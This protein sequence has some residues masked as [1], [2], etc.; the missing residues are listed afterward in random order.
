MINIK[1]LTF[2]TIVFL[3]L[4]SNIYANDT[5]SNIEIKNKKLVTDLLSSILKSDLEGVKTSIKLGADV[6]IYLDNNN[7]FLIIEAVKI[8]NIDIIKELVE[9]GADVDREDT[10]RISTLM[11]AS[12]NGHLEVVKYLVAN[13]SPMYDISN[14][15]TAFSLAIENGHDDIAKYIK[16]IS[17][18]IDSANTGDFDQVKKY[19]EKG[20]PV[21]SLVDFD[22]ALTVASE[23]GHLEIVQYL[24]DNGAKVNGTRPYRG[25]GDTALSIA[26][27]NGHFEIVK[28]LIKAGAK[29]NLDDRLGGTALMGASENGHVKIVKLLIDNGADINAKTYKYSTALIMS[30]NY[31]VSKLLLDNGADVKVYNNLGYTALYGVTDIKLAKLLIDKGADLNATLVNDGSTPLIEAVRNNNFKIVKLLVESGADMSIKD[32]EEMTALQIAC[33]LEHKEICNYLKKPI[34]EILNK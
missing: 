26:S 9:S 2:L 27:Q 34:K 33:N 7:S 29:V 18:F 3:F 17:I 25:I 24:I 11:Y 12:K 8:G 5:V 32:Y 31:K 1:N 15:F 20:I 13:G 10:G 22:T 28:V 30:K 23:N 14:D 19:I 21:D 16:D 6:N 4:S